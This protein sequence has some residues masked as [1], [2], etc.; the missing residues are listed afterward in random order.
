MSTAIPD[1][2]GTPTRDRRPPL[3]YARLAG[4][5]YLLAMAL[6]IFSQAYVLGRLVG[7]DAAGTAQQ[8]AASEGLFR[9]GI[10]VDVVTAVTDIVIAWAF[11]E[12]LKSVDGR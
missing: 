11:Y 9:L 2:T 7:D 10:V 8:I 5:I 6:G 4:F 12:L 1:L 3:F